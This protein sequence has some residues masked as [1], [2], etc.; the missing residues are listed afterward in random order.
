MVIMEIG[1]HHAAHAIE[2]WVLNA[3]ST[4]KQ[5]VSHDS[6]LT[7]LGPS[8]SGKTHIIRTL[9]RKHNIK[10]LE[11]CDV[12]NAKDLK[13]QILKVATTH[14]IEN[15]E[16]I[17]YTSK[18]LLID[19]LDIVLSIDRCIAS[20]LTEILH[21]K[22]KLPYVPVVLVGSPICE[23]KLGTQFIN[24]CRYVT[25]FPPSATDIFLFLKS[26]RDGQSLEHLMKVAEDCSGNI[27]NALQQIGNGSK[28]LDKTLVFTD[29]FSSQ[30]DGDVRTL[31]EEEPWLNPLR[32]HEN[33]L[34]ELDQRRGRAEVKQRVYQRILESLTYWDALMPVNPSIACEQIIQGIRAH[35]HS[36]PRKKAA[37][38][39]G[40]NEFT[41]L[42]SHMSLQKKHER[43]T[44]CNFLQ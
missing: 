1:N 26:R 10:L 25:F 28:S 15:L 9:A 23:R 12:E 24:K 38:D 30:N 6:C 19:N 27:S 32:F 33:L 44:Y 3:T 2:D 29:V 37:S 18:V 22:S 31:L 21:H 36:L 5:Y 42:F 43:A 13:D 4:N 14:L 41:K 17:Q 7:I 39:Q 35:L 34:R 40:L 8:G 16:Q 20:S 11:I